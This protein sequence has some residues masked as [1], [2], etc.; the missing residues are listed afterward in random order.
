MSIKEALIQIL[1]GDIAEAKIV[2]LGKFGS[3]GLILRSEDAA[4]KEEFN[5]SNITLF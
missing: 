4:G 5:T 2:K 3:F 1:P